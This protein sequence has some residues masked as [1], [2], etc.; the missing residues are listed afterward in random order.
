MSASGARWCW[1]WVYGYAEADTER[2][3]AWSERLCEAMRPFG[4]G[5]YLGFLMED[6]Q[7]RIGE[8]YPPATL[9]RLR[10]VKRRYDPT[11]VFHHNLNIEPAAE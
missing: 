8:V 1:L 9:E 4:T 10:Q 3:V 5:A 2:H 7:E 11:N 6:G